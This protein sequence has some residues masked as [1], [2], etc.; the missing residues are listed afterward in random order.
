MYISA[1][2]NPTPAQSRLLVAVLMVGAL[3]LAFFTYLGQENRK[4]ALYSPLVVPIMATTSISP[5]LVVNTPF[6]LKSRRTGALCALEWIHCLAAMFHHIYEFP[7]L[8]SVAGYTF[9]IYAV[10]MQFIKRIDYE[11]I[12]KLGRKSSLKH[13]QPSVVASKVD[14]VACA[15]VL[16]YFLLWKYFG[17][18]FVLSGAGPMTVLAPF[19]RHKIYASDIANFG[20]LGFLF[21]AENL[22]VI[23]GAMVPAQVMHFVSH[24][25]ISYVFY[26]SNVNH[27]FPK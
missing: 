7:F 17:P 25:A 16:F 23:Q 19:I 6:M 1:L 3:C 4:L 14:T 13:I 2:L 10:L 24:F 9:P 18:I 15:A 12:E 11:S 27:F 8:V 22:C 20:L 21:T 26:Q 5:F